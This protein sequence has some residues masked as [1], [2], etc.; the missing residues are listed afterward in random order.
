MISIDCLNN[1]CFFFQLY[2]INLFYELLNLKPLPN[3]TTFQEAVLLSDPSTFR[4][5]WKLAEGFVAFEGLDLVPHISKSRPN[6]IE[7]HMSLT[8]QC[9]LKC[10]L[11]EALVKVIVG[12]G[13]NYEYLSIIFLIDF[14]VKSTV[15]L[16]FAGSYVVSQSYS[17][18]GGTFTP[19][20]SY[21]TSRG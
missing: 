7:N 6:L 10:D 13:V 16:L 20:K 5:T 8:L 17:F 3:D 19:R 18:T 4:D 2:L 11:P 21:S 1:V 14:Y 9:L 15:C 12:T